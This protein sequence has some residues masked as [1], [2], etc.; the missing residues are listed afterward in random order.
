M[1]DVEDISTSNSSSKDNSLEKLH[2]NDTINSKESIQAKDNWWKKTAGKTSDQISSNVSNAVNLKKEQ[3]SKSRL[4]KFAKS[5]GVA[6][7]AKFLA[8]GVKGQLKEYDAIKKAEQALKKF[9][10][11]IKFIV[12][13]I[14]IIAIIAIVIIIVWN[15]VIECISLSQS[16]ISS[17][18]YYCDLE[19]DEGTKRS[20]LFNTYRRNK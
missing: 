12:S 13:H 4:A 15:V 11:V 19:A 3:L 7:K 6:G 8:N 5:D 10:N 9:Q 2:S 20:K 18:H 14:K 17:P 16:I 1:S